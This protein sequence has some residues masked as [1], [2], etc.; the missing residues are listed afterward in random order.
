MEENHIIEKYKAYREIGKEL[1]GKLFRFLSKEEMS[2][3]AFLFNLI[4]ETG[5]YCFS[6]EADQDRFTDFLIHDYL[7]KESKNAVQK[8]IESEGYD[9][10]SAIDKDIIE[11]KTNSIQSLFLLDYTKPDEGLLGLKDVF[12]SFKSIEILDIGLSNCL[13]PQK[14]YIFTRIMQFDEFSCTTG[15]AHIFDVKKI[16]K[17]KKSYS[18]YTKIYSN[19][20]FRT[21]KSVAFYHV[22]K[23]HGKPVGYK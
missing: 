20:K 14:N 5:S 22:N 12:N 13:K 4:D 17:I 19:L 1:N 9:L 23:Q 2:K 3:G 18:K 15:I 8:L 16:N 6:D 10:F 21:K 7:D 11:A